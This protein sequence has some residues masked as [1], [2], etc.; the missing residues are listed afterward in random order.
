MELDGEVHAIVA[1]D[2]RVRRFHVGPVAEAMQAV[3]FAHFTL[4]RAAKRAPGPAGC[5]R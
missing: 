2:G 1:D 3:D 5:G 4:R